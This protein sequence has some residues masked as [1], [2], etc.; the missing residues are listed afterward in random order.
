M[1]HEKLSWPIST[2]SMGNT[3]EG[4]KQPPEVLLCKKS[5][6]KNLA[7]L[8]GRQLYWS[9][10]EQNC[11]P[12]GVQLYLKETPTQ[13]LSC[14]NLLNFKNTYFQKNICERL[15][16]ILFFFFFLFNCCLVAPRPISGH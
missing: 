8:T 11:R 3:S 1:R 2:K 7:N 16:L 12:E 5:L 10:F 4:S 9:L 15:L 14:K 13:V 6:F